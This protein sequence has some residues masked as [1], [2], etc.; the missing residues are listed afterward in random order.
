MPKLIYE[1]DDGTQIPFDISRE[2]L[3]SIKEAR[4]EN[5]DPWDDII[6]LFGKEVKRIE[7]EPGDDE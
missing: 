3:S 1:A 2:L 6:E 7:S 4:G 5:S